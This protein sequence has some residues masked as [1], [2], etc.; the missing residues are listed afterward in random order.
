MPI[1]NHMR[2]AKAKALEE[3]K[4]YGKML[5]KKQYNVK[6]KHNIKRNGGKVV[7]DRSML[8]AAKPSVRGKER[9]LFEDDDEETSCQSLYS[10]WTETEDEA[11]YAS[12]EE[13]KKRNFDLFCRLLEAKYD[14]SQCDQNVD[15]S[16]KETM[17]KN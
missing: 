15:K 1:V 8:L 7:C 2:K 10:N 5:N 16:N 11:S 6:K 17:K 9:G 14:S 13:L 12:Y 3:V 4:K